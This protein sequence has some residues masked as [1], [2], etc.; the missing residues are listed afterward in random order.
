MDTD[1]LA[2]IESELDSCLVL[3]GV[4]DMTTMAQFAYRPY[5]Y[6][7]YVAALQRFA[8][9]IDRSDPTSDRVHFTVL[10]SDVRSDLPFLPIKTAV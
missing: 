9:M 2:G 5:D 4:T 6:V 8:K 3:S 1:I 7:A 10:Q